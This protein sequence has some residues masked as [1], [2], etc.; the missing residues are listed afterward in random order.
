MTLMQRIYRLLRGDKSQTLAAGLLLLFLF[1]LS[2]LAPLD[3]LLRLVAIG[4]LLG[5][6]LLAAIFVFEP[7]PMLRALM[8]I[9]AATGLL[10]AAGQY[11][12]DPTIDAAGALFMLVSAVML[13]LIYGSRA[14]RDGRV[15]THRMMG[16]VVAFLLVGVVFAQAF[17][18][19]AHLSPGAFA[20]RGA[21]A[22]MAEI[23]PRLNDFS[24]ITLSSVGFGDVTPVHP[25]ARTLATVEALVGALLLAILIARLVAKELEWRREQRDIAARARVAL[26][27]DPATIRARVAEIYV[28]GSGIEIGALNEPMK[29]PPG[30]LVRYVDLR[31]PAEL[32]LHYPQL[33]PRSLIPIDVVDDGE[34]LST[35][36]DGSIDFIIANQMLEHCENPLGTIRQHL[37]K[38]KPGGSLFYALPDKRV[39]FDA[40]RPITPFEHLVA[41]D[42]DGGARSRFGHYLEWSKLVNGVDDDKEAEA[43]ARENVARRYSIHYHVWDSNAW[44][45]FLVRAREYL[46]RAFD[47]RFCQFTGTEV[48]CVLRKV[49]S[50]GTANGPDDL[51]KSADHEHRPKHDQS[52]SDQP[53]RVEGLVQEE[54]GAGR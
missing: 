54:R 6:L 45:E 37:R 22:S 38:V 3:A 8:V 28:R 17:R 1:V 24:F 40:Q 43:Q 46:G 31:T 33:E 29:V 25:V 16:A 47:I 7:R 53:N 2:P 49:E 34:K 26:S 30:T 23:L 18:V 35:F 36:A 20:L 51:T 11:V 41:D 21:P 15:N 42:A 39:T 19:T 50:S 9:L 48:V 4:A 52:H 27:E 5:F 12:D 32:A 44:F 14:L 13:A 10:Y